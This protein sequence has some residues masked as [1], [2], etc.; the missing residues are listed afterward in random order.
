MY[1]LK[2]YSSKPIYVISWAPKPGLKDK[3]DLYACINGSVIVYENKSKDSGNKKAYNCKND[4]L[5][6]Q[7]FQIR[8]C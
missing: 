4:R 3:F 5:T 2:H 6:F 8:E 7:L 1:Y